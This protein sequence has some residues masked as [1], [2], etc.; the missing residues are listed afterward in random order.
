[1]AKTRMP[2]ELAADT[3]VFM[4]GEPVVKNEKIRLKNFGYLDQVITV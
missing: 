2:F 1:M 4:T 3:I